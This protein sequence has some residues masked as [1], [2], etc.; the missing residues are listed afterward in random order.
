[1]VLVKSHTLPEITP[2]YDYTWTAYLE[3]NVYV[4]YEIKVML[5]LIFKL[6][7]I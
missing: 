4:F 3:L 5:K 7:A 1:M 6:I 2:S